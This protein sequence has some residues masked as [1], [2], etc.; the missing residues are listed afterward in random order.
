[1]VAACSALPLASVPPRPLAS[2][3]LL[4]VLRL[5]VVPGAL[6]PALASPAPSPDP[7][8]FNNCSG[9]GT[10]RDFSCSCYH[11]F[12]GD[13]CRHTF[14][15]DPGAVVPILGA[16]HYNLTAKNFSKA[17]SKKPLMLVGFS[18]PTCH[19][20]ITYEPEYAAAAEALR[21]MKVPFA[22]ANIDKFREHLR[23]LGPVELP[24]LVV[25]KK[26]RRCVRVRLRLRLR[27]HHEQLPKWRAC[28]TRQVPLAPNLCRLALG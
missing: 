14:A 5:L 13:D 9:H 15:A 1:M 2:L 19:K 3:A 24:L 28:S 6:P 20:C 10:C 7:I 17:V 22:R 4:V 12:F 16:G 27:L 26:K 23:D 21:S 8:C 11:G 25:Y 18:S